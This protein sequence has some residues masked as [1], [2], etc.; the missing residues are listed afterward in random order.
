MAICDAIPVAEWRVQFWSCIKTNG[1]VHT[2]IRAGFRMRFSICESP[3]LRP[4]SYFLDK[5]RCQL[6]RRGRGITT[7][8]RRILSLHSSA[9]NLCAAVVLSWFCCV[10]KLLQNVDLLYRTFNTVQKFFKWCCRHSIVI[11][12]FIWVW[13]YF[14]RQHMKCSFSQA[15]IIN[16]M[17]PHFSVHFPFSISFM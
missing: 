13:F 8:T 12:K 15:C 2:A 4:P 1:S 14:L 6:L 11:K 10:L 16:R 7:F 17:N 9:Y 5:V 3:E